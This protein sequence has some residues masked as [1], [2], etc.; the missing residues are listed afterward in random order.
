MD[1]S[2]RI[3][4]SEAETFIY[5]EARFADEHRYD[6]WASLWT[7]D[8]IYWIP[9]NADDYDP[10]RHLSIIYDNR[11]RLRDRVDRLKSGKAWAQEPRSRLRRLISNIETAFLTEKG[12]LEVRSNFVLGECRKGVQTTY[13]AHQIH[14]LRSTPEGIRMS[15]KKV[16]LI[17]NDE[18]IHNMSFLV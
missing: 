18:P 10:R 15:F 4:R 12:E 8:C 3:E 1:T 5:R 14:N 6:E 11:N 9:S 7:E 2:S 17:N 16:L 13:F